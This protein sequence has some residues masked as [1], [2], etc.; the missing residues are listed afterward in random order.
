MKKPELW[1]FIAPLDAPGLCHVLATASWVAEKKGVLYECY[2]ECFRDGTL[3]AQTGSTVLGGSHAQQFN[4]LHARCE[5][6]LF[7]LGGQS[8]F[9]SSC[10]AF[11]DETAVEAKDPDEF[12]EKLFAYAGLKPSKLLFA[13]ER[14][15][16]GGESADIAPY[17]TSEI[18]FGE[19]CAWPSSRLD[20][21]TPLPFPDAEQYTALLP[22]SEGRV[23][24]LEALPEDD[25]GSLTLRLARRQKARARGVA[26]G[27]PDAIRSRVPSLCR[28]RRVS[29][30]APA[31]WK[32]PPETV[33]GSY[34]ES[35]SAIARETALLA[36]ELGNPVLVGRQTCDGDLFLWG[37]Y[38]VSIRIMDPNRPAFPV[39]EALRQ[40]WVSLP[41]TLWDEEPD[42]AVLEKWASEGKILSA[43]LFHSGEMAHNEA[44][45][46]LMD[47][48][49]ATGL[50]LGIGAHLARYETC[51]QSWELLNVPRERGG[52]R[53]LIEPVLHS[54]GLGIMAEKDC[55]A[56]ALTA[57]CRTALERIRSIAGDAGVPRGY[58]FFCDTD[59]DT[60]SSIRPELYDAVAEAGLEYAITNARPGKNRLL[61]APIPVLT[62]TSRTICG[63]SPFVRITSAEDV[64]ESGFAQ[65]PGWFIGVLDAPVI[66]FA[67]YVWRYGSR[68]T[69]LADRI[70]KQNMINVLPSTVARYA[71]IL[72]RRGDLA[73]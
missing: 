50:K 14:L 18:F 34:A 58:Y 48:C 54:G 22:P 20:D 43:L 28:E 67:P 13:P 32:T 25:W 41:G 23:S 3:F 62:Q 63:G 38:G 68:F 40:P 31:R 29:V 73:D 30:Y 65:A 15:Q 8:V 39:V 1:L 6:K 53:G 70:A 17:L 51:P 5:V 11:G 42:D 64:L 4:Y 46:N 9:A 2:L 52:V 59:L 47:L 37:S 56:D 72:R 21:P 69:A 57:H 49:A 7:V 16:L 10:A 66:A 26:F 61:P 60:L 71:A 36:L 27:D 12:Y 19:Y 45:L 44:M 35:S 33:L 55:P 24:L